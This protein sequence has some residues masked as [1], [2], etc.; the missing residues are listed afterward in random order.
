MVKGMWLMLPHKHNTPDNYVLSLVNNIREFVEKTFKHVGKNIVWEDEGVNEIGKD[1][2][3]I[4]IRV[5]PR[6]L[7]PNVTRL[8]IY[9]EI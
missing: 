5:N 4:Y 1:S 3:K 2:G 9:Y 8:V 6:Y 7:R